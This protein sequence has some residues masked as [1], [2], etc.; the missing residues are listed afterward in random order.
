MQDFCISKNF[1]LKTF[2]LSKK[3]VLV[4]FIFYFS[5]LNAQ[6][7]GIV[8]SL[9]LALM[10]SKSDTVRC[11]TYDKLIDVISNPEEQIKLNDQ[12]KQ[13][14]QVNVNKTTSTHPLNFFYN[15]HLANAYNNS[16][17]L[18]QHEGNLEK[19]LADNFKSLHIREQIKDFNG[20]AQSL[21]NLG[22]FYFDRGNA[23]KAFEYFEKS[24]KIRLQLK[25]KYTIA[26]SYNNLAGLYDSQGDTIRAR[27]LY[28][29]GLIL[30]K[31]IGDKKGISSSLNNLAGFYESQGDAAKALDYY[32]RSLY[33]IKELNDKTL[34]A[35]VYNN[36]GQIYMSQ[37]NF[38]STMVYF[39]KSLELYSSVQ[40]K[41][42]QAYV[43]ENMGSAMYYQKNYSKAKE[44]GERSLSISKVL[45]VPEL[46]M[47]NSGLLKRVYK[48]L[49]D[50][51][52][53]L[54]MYE[55][56]IL[57]RDSLSNKS[58]REATMKSQFQYE[59]DKK[60]VVMKEKQEQE[61]I[62]SHEKSRRMKIIIG[63]VVG[64]L[65][66]LL[67]FSIFI[68]N[69]LKITQKQKSIIENQKQLVEVHQR[70]I[71]DSINYA[72]RLQDAILPPLEEIKKHLP[73]HFILYLPKDIVAG[74]FYWFEQKDDLIF[75]A[76]ADCTGHGVPG[77]LV[78]VVCS[79]ALNR[80]VLEFELTDPGQILDKTRELVINTF[81]K[82]GDTNVKD[83]MDIS[84]CCINKKSNEVLWAGANNPLWY[85]HDNTFCE[86]KGDK[87]PIGKTENPTAF[88]TRRVQLEKNDMVYIFTDGYSDQFGGNKGK[89]F[90]H[91]QLNDILK[92]STSHSMDEQKNILNESFVRWKGNLEQ[93]D[94]V[95]IVGFRM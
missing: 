16:T 76:A 33:T 83:G 67:I 47:A 5:C 17:V 89:K 63:F 81:A 15:R 61:K 9:K 72:K 10:N 52:K 90:K 49:N 56:F 24:L 19:A 27:E 39:N 35:T 42:G 82:S 28:T 68:Y 45:G 7:D 44:Y 87:Q 26:E 69:R 1:Y 31:E 46:M 40:D 32:N 70:E 84:L 65:I 29:K 77:A 20:V 48:K 74:D 91:K 60:E 12:Y 18:A 94:D 11:N 73:D 34:T 95:C 8:D 85:F 25:N 14:S 58:N 43:L 6:K 2:F 64:G 4:F 36:I 55:T 3:M 88:N 66:L 21:N 41:T 53:A 78:S 22:F 75:I 54:E 92:S 50:P 93:V 57:M 30:R 79:N 86:I 62:L 23:P 80:T 51:A 71:L 59:F 38:D 13:L 37:R